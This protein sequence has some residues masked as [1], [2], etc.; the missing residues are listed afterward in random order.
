M[1]KKEAQSK[2]I[3]EKYKDGDIEN[4]K[5]PKYD[6][7]GGKTHKKSDGYKCPKCG[8]KF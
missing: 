3:A 5:E 8:T 6:T 4:K 1:D 7:E 2:A